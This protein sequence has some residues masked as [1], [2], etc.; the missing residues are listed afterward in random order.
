M[1]NRLLVLGVALVLLSGCTYFATQSEKTQLQ[2]RSYQTRSWPI[3]DAKLIMKACINVLQDDGYAV[4]NAVPDVGLIVAEKSAKN[5]SFGEWF[6]FGISTVNRE[7][8]INITVKKNETT[9]RANFLDRKSNV[10]GGPFSVV[11]IDDEKFY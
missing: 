6:W 1:E 8:T 4:K 5:E 3:A 10:Y 2:I 9:V 7:A 11:Q